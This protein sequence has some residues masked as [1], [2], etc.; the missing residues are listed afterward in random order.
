M[1]Q[2]K[3]LTPE[4]RRERIRQA[5][6]Q[7][8]ESVARLMTADGWRAAMERRA[9][10]R[11]YSLSNVMMILHQ[12]PGATDVRPL[13][14]W[15]AAGRHV[16]KG[17][18]AIKI[19]APSIRK[20][21]PASQPDD[22]EPGDTAETITVRFILVNVF[23]VSQTDGAPL[24]KV[25]LA[26]YCPELLSGDAPGWLWDAVAAEV[27]ALGYT[28]ERGDCDGANARVTWATRT[29]RV[30]DDVDGAQAAK[31]LI[32]EFAHILCDHEH[33]PD[34]PRPLREVE[35]E[36]VACIVATACGLDTLPYSVPYVAGWAKDLDIATRS[37]ER[38]Y[39]VAD[40]ILAR[41][42][43]PVPGSEAAGAV[44]AAATAA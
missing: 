38:I 33:R 15:N 35:A 36:S 32:H 11:R 20:P 14:Q 4:Q 34:A 10:L 2:R 16:R 8:T 21:D 7:L 24:P 17:E 42:G 27:R 44:P 22:T 40:T 25:T 13:R 6:E 1:R 37:A 39:A 12:C 23:D 30:R 28:I 19:W 5:H 3:A 18:H 41:L 43:I 31:S 9:W 29:V 26:D